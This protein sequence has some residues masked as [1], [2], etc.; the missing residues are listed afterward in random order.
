MFGSHSKKLNKVVLGDVKVMCLIEPI[1]SKGLVRKNLYSLPLPLLVL[2]CARPNFRAFK[3]PKMLQTYGK[4]YRNACYAG[5]RLSSSP[6]LFTEECDNLKV[7][8]LKL[9]YPERLINSTITRFIE[10]QNQEQVRDVQAN[11]PVR[12]ILPF[13]DKKSADT[14]RRQLSDLGRK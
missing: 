14:V 1:L 8:F 11:A 13:K 3:K 5:Y 2:F 9:K 4:P 6:D 7:I 12:I 10:S